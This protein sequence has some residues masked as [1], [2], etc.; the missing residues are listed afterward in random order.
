[1]IKSGRVIR[2]FDDE[3]LVVNLGTSDGV[4]K[5]ATLS[6][7]APPVEIKDPETDEDLGTYHHPK[8]NVRAERVSEKFCVAGPFPVSRQ[9]KK[10]TGPSTLFQQF[11]TEYRTEPGELE[12]E[13][14]EANP[15]PSGTAIRVGDPVYITLPDEEDKPEDA[16]S[17]TASQGPKASE[18]AE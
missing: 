5:G 18:D 16:S 6:I 14:A 12:I 1:L 10:P 13:E 7:F 15:L 2:I 3:N 9:V 4:T 8:A 17:S 11:Q